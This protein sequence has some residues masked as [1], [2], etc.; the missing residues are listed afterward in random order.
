MSSSV[1]VKTEPAF[2]GRRLVNTLRRASV[3]LNPLI[4]LEDWGKSILK[5]T[6]PVFALRIS[7]A[8]DGG[9][10]SVSTIPTL[11]EELE[12]QLCERRPWDL[13]PQASWPSG[14]MLSRESRKRPRS[15][16]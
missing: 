3:H 8:A 10:E 1:L 4:V 9:L 6:C 14:A 13:Y 7:S 2:D 12:V 11:L 15:N 16:N 5:L